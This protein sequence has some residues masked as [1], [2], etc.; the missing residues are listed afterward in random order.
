MTPPNWAEV[1]SAYSQL[2][3]TI[4]QGV[5]VITALWLALWQLRGLNKTLKLSALSSLLQIET[6]ITA[7]KEKVDSANEQ[8][9]HALQKKD[10]DPNA[11]VM[12]RAKQ[13][14]ARENWFNALDRLCLCIR[15]GYWTDI[16]WPVEYQDYLADVV[17]QFPASFDANSPYPHIVALHAEWSKPNAPTRWAKLL[18][19]V[20]RSWTRCAN[21]ARAA[22]AFT[23]G[24]STAF[25]KRSWSCCVG[26]GRSAMAYMKRLPTEKR[27]SFVFRIMGILFVIAAIVKALAWFFHWP[28]PF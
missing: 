27:L 8:A 26:G 4:F 10:A 13:N 25:V 9:Y 11:E 22:M 23:K 24:L 7:R 5:A 20:K 19:F 6:D 21:A 28:Q 12:V 16:D 17:K 2:W 1:W 18:A 15:K 3:A 14:T